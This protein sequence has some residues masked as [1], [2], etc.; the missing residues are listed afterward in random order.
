MSIKV[1]QAV[2]WPQRVEARR[3][4]DGAGVDGGIEG[5]WKGGGNHDRQVQKN[6]KKERKRNKKYP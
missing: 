1:L 3:R 4:V 5:E 2:K 6:K